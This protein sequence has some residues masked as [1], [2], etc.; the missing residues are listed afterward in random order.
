[1]KKIDFEKCKI[2]PKGWPNYIKIVY[3][4]ETS[5]L[6]T[7]VSK[8]VIEVILKLN[9]GVVGTKVPA[10]LLEAEEEA[11]VKGGMI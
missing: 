9:G 2:G 7:P 10:K 5:A 1:M 6:Y 3:K 11:Y 4:G 8:E